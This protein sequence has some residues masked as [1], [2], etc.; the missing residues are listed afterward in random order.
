M[1]TLRNGDR[2]TVKVCKWN[3]PEIGRPLEAV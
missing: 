3:E 2:V 1:R